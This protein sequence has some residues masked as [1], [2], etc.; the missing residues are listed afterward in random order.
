MINNFDVHS[1]D[2]EDINENDEDLANELA[3]FVEPSPRSLPASSILSRPAPVIPPNSQVQQPPPVPKRIFEIVTENNQNKVPKLVNQP[4]PVSEG[5]ALEYVK[6][7]QAEY[8][9]AAL[10]AKQSGDKEAALG[11]LKISKVSEI[12]GFQNLSFLSSAIRCCFG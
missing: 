8:K 1:E 7:L 9:R 2:D 11:H 10:K 5:N 4:N 12:F 6:K 3:S